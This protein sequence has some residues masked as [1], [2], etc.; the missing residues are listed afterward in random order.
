MPAHRSTPE[1]TAARPVPATT[2]ALAD[3]ARLAG[4]GRWLGPW[5]GAIV[6]AVLLDG[7]TVAEVAEWLQRPA[8]QVEQELVTWVRR[9]GSSRASV[10]EA[11]WSCLSPLEQAL[12]GEWVAG[13]SPEEIARTLGSDANTVSH[14]L[15]A[16]EKKLN[17][18]SG[19]PPSQVRQGR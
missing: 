3:D 9:L 4:A 13:R 16:L 6:Q 5:A 7:W 11:G 14:R 19:L 15:A 8:E 17:P 2:T 1:G 10:V 12:A 18:L